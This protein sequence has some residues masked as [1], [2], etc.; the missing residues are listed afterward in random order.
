VKEKGEEEKEKWGDIAGGGRPGGGEG[1]RFTKG[2]FFHLMWNTN[3]TDDY[4]AEVDN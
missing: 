4:I 3:V 2:L 1:D